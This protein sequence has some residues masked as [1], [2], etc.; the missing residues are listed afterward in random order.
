MHIK[1]YNIVFFILTLFSF[2]LYLFAPNKYDHQWCYVCF[3]LFLISF[4]L[5]LKVKKKE[6]YFD[7]EN[8]FLFSCLFVYFVYP[9]FVYPLNPKMF[10]MFDFSFNHDVITKGT[11]LALLGLQSFILG[12]VWKGSYKKTKDSLKQDTLKIFDTKKITFAHSLFFVLFFAV[13]YDFFL[14]KVYRGGL[15]GNTVY[16]YLIYQSLLTIALVL[17]FRN[18]YIAKIQGI[19]YKI[20]KLVLF[21]TIFTIVAYLYS[22]YRSAAIYIILILGICYSSFY[23]PIKLK[24]FLISVFV[25]ALLMT[26]IALSRSSSIE[27]NND[28]R[29]D[30]IILGATMDLIINARTLYVCVDYVQNNDILYG[31]TMIVTFFSFVP[32]SQ[33]ILFGLNILDISEASS[34]TFFTTLDFGK[35]STFGVGSNIIADIFL[36]F[37]MIGVIFFMFALGRIQVVFYNFRF[38]NNIKWFFCY[39]VIM[40]N[41]LYM[42]RGEYFFSMKNI[43]WVNFIFILMYNIQNQ[44]KRIK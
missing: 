13:S 1:K 9:C 3:G 29:G 19:D 30:S 26:F 17:E 5:L 23:K 8:I 28:F 7:F 35:H 27:E 20:N 10:F 39:A 11:S 4:L 18:L 34:G 14:R 16:V 38:K 40:G 2:F 44:Y 36:S 6:N 41:V 21:F 24:L 31:K 43:F 22:G 33:R 42:S 37:G 32:F 25:G 15:E 12:S